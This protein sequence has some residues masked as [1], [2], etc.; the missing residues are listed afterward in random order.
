M[1]VIKTE[2]NNINVYKYTGVARAVRKITYLEQIP[3]EAAGEFL[4]N[5][6]TTDPGSPFGDLVATPPATKRTLKRKRNEQPERPK[7]RRKATVHVPKDDRQ[8]RK[9]SRHALTNRDTISFKAFA[10]VIPP[11]MHTQRWYKVYR[12]LQGTAIAT[13]TWD[14]YK[15]AFNKYTMYCVTH[16]IEIRWPIRECYV[17]GF[18]L[19]C[20]GEE[21]LAP[22][23]VKSYIFAL[24]HLQQVFGFGKIPFSQNSIAKFLVKGAKNWKTTHE[25]QKKRDT[26][27]LPRLQK[28]FKAISKS[29]WP[30]LNKTTFWCLCLVAFYGSFRLG[31]LLAK[32]PKNFDKTT[33][34]LTKHV[35][36]D[37]KNNTW[38]IWIKSPKTGNAQGENVYLFPVPQKDFCPVEELKKY[39]NLLVRTGKYN[40]DLPL[41]R[42][43]SGK[44]VTIKKVNKVLAHIF[45]PKE[46]VRITGHCFR[47]GLISSAGNLPDI[48]NDT[49]LKGWGRWRTDTFLRYEIFDME[50][51]KYIFKKLLQS[52]F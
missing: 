19:W 18:V 7:G 43:K 41:F 40:T 2:L 47:S 50:Q 26:I 30:E 38:T 36:Y 16:A 39:V 31:E 52:L 1:L 9:Y 48:V 29:S 45:P 24:S 15:S 35:T 34:L 32:Q 28:I 44:C 33:T 49:H 12:R 4:D 51:K 21:D 6:Y 20:L 46:G 25:P 37:D 10:A 14:K 17:N 8:C 3:L 42:W 27:T 23:T 5:P 22:D 13:G 11:E